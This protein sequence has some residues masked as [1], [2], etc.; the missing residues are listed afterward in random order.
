MFLCTE[1]EWMFVCFCAQSASGCLCVSVHRARVDVCVFL[2]TEREWMFVCFCVYRVWVDVW[3][4]VRVFVCT[5]WV[6]VC[7]YKVWVDVCVYKVWADVCVY[8]VWVGVRL[9]VC[10]EIWLMFV[11][12]CVHT[13]V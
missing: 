10:T 1:R 13:A 5:V 11:C 9:L 2:C 7:V 3:V 6:D 12:L 8:R 4:G